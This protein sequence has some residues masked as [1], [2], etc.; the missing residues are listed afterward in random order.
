MRT[1]FV[2]VDLENVQP[3]SIGLS[4]GGPLKIKVFL[5]ATQCKIPLEM[6]RALQ[7]FGPDVEYIQMD[8]NGT[9]A[10]D[11]HIAYY[12]GRLAAAYPDAYFHI[13]SKDT[14][15]DPL[16]K[17]LK[18]Q[19]IFCQRSAAV[20]DIPM[21][22]VANAESVPERVDALL[23]RLIKHKAC[24]PRTLETLRNTIKTCF[25]NKLSDHEIQALL[26]QLAQRGV[27]RVSEGKVVYELPA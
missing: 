22:K 5:G 8:G 16:I 19:R 14:G 20:T 10:L 3:K 9:N 24:K 11:F 2:L 6:V 26:D 15:F 13:I 17:H 27:I 18:A 1:N 23:D 12:I 21:I 25:A 4:Y 7:A